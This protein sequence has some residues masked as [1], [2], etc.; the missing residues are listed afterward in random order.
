MNVKPAFW[1]C[2]CLCLCLSPVQWASASSVW[3]FVD[4]QGV[5]H[6]GNV[7]A[8]SNPKPLQRLTPHA[9]PI[10][11]SGY[12]AAKPWLESAARQHN[13]DP[14]LVTAIAAAESGFRPNAVSRKGA[15]GLMQIMPATGARYGVSIASQT[16]TSALIQDPELNAQVGSR[17]LADLLR[18]F[19][20]EIELA[21]AAYNAGEGAVLRHGG[22]VPPFPETQQYVAKVMQL[23]RVLTS[24]GTLGTLGG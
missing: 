11:W 10:R 2:L 13:L 18:Q 22:R 5:T 3:S 20:G 15:L 17:Y 24:V 19:N 1:M 8:A 9:N 16:T 12:T 14:A 7:A 23:Y 4:E 21:I 6:I